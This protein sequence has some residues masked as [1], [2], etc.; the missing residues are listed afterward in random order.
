MELIEFSMTLSLAF[1]KLYL[2]RIDW[3]TFSSD[4]G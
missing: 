2:K 4:E 1:L 3:F